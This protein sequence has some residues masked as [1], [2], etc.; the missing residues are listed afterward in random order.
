M[1]RTLITISQLL[2]ETQASLSGFRRTLRKHDQ[3]I[4]DGLFASAS[5]HIAAIG[6]SD[7]LL[8][9]ETALLAILLEQAKEIALLQHEIELLKLKH[10]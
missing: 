4:F 9:F 3:Y 7:S 1:G 5:L 8:P 6:Q 2:K 10:E